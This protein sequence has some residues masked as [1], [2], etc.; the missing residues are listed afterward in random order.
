MREIGYKKYNRGC[1]D[2]YGYFMQIYCEQP[3][4]FY[5]ISSIFFYRFKEKMKDTNRDSKIITDDK[6]NCEIK[7]KD[8]LENFEKENCFDPTLQPMY[9]AQ[10]LDYLLSNMKSQTF[11]EITDY[12]KTNLLLFYFEDN[13]FI[14]GPYV[15]APCDD[16]DIH[17][18][19][20]SQ[21]LSSSVFH[22]IKL[23]YDRFPLVNYVQLTNIILSAMRAFVPLTMDFNHRNL[24]GFHEELKISEIQE[25]SESSYLQILKRYENENF[26]LNKIE[27]GDLDGVLSALNQTTNNFYKSDL[28]AQKNYYATNQEGFS[29][30]R[31]L[32]RKAAE[33]GGCPVIK[34]DEITQEAI[35]KANQAH[36]VAE[37]SKIQTNMLI[38]LTKAVA[39]SKALNN[40]SLLI[41]SIVMYIDSNYSKEISL[42]AIAENSH[43]S[44]EHLSRTFKKETGITLSDYIARRRTK[45]AGELLKTTTLSISEISSFVGYS[46]NNYFVK[47]FKKHYGMTPSKY[48]MMH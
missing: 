48:R 13:Y 26:F 33:R 25:S 40:Y 38:A 30:L 15:K 21:R 24:Q 1:R 29:I 43:V 28:T 37:L 20:A 10:Y 14:V 34:I 4:D 36:S 39:E 19:L 3:S 16:K 32:A 46:D 27:S 12:L 44:K 42:S 8:L 11:Y 35:Q 45:K 2:E 5:S 17:E 47:I 6:T 18:F 22:Q 31:T 9:S 23:Y 7:R 41:R